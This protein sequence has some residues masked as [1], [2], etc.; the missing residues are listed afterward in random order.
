MKQFDI[1]ELSPPTL[2]MVLASRTA[3]DLVAAALEGSKDPE[4]NERIDKF[5][6]S[7][8]Q[9]VVRAE[10]WNL[11]QSTAAVALAYVATR[12]SVDFM[13]WSDTKAGG[14]E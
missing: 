4:I 14:Q 10:E 8:Q 11:S 1:Y 13:T 9:L 3:S 2:Q 7:A 6:E 5:M 12:M